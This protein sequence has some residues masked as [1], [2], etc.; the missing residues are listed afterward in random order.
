MIFKNETL[1]EKNLLYNYLMAKLHKYDKIAS[2]IIYSVSKEERWNT[3]IYKIIGSP[4]W[5]KAMKRRFLWEFTYGAPVFCYECETLL[6][7]EN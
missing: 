4:I 7:L 1:V 2:N 5:E 6:T 3:Y